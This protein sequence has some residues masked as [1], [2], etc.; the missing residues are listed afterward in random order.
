[1]AGFK[2]VEDHH[3]RKLSQRYQTSLGS[4]EGQTLGD[5]ENGQF[6]VRLY[7]GEDELLFDILMDNDPANSYEKEAFEPLEVMARSFDV[8][9]MYIWNQRLRD[10]ELL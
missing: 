3:H 4:L 1:M 7:G 8:N 2:I 5:Y 10:Y 6:K 9:E